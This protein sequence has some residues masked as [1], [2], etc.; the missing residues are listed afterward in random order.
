MIPRSAPGAFPV[1]NGD[2]MRKIRISYETVTP[3]SAAE[4]DIADSGWIEEE[5]ITIDPDEYDIEEHG[6]KSAA[7]VAMVIETIGRYVEPSASCFFPGVWYTDVD[8]NIDYRTG[9]EN[10]RSYHLSGFSEDEE[11]LIFQAIQAV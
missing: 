4:G 1:V 6:G 5:G 3:E 9:A 2:D 7:V 10:R 8:S 11:K